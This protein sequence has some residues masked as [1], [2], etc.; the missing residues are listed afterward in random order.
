MHNWRKGSAVILGLFL[1]TVQPSW[2]ANWACGQGIHGGGGITGWGRTGTFFGAPTG[3]QVWPVSAGC[4]H[5][6]Q[7]MAC[8]PGSAMPLNFSVNFSRLGPGNTE[9]SFDLVAGTFSTA[10]SGVAG[11]VPTLDYDAICTNGHPVAFSL[12]QIWDAPSFTQS[13]S[14]NVN[15]V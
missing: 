1:A 2:A 14:T 10:Q 7:V 11:S 6:N 8:E 13:P 9:V 15:R 3:G 4:L 5:R 12:A